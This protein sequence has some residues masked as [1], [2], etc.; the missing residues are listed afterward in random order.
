MTQTPRLV[1][2]RLR[3]RWA[4]ALTAAVL[5]LA[6]AADAAPAKRRRRERA[7]SAPAPTQQDPAP[8]SS[9]EPDEAAPAPAKKPARAESTSGAAAGGGSLDAQIR[10]K[11]ATIRNHRRSIA[12]AVERAGA[13]GTEVFVPQGTVSSGT[14]IPWSSVHAGKKISGTIQAKSSGGKVPADVT[15]KAVK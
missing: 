3:A 9:S 8:S 14:A 5:L 1:P 11:Q 2:P 10:N 13:G 12:E 4:S 7:G 6:F 15:A